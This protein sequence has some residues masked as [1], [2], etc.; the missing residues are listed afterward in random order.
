MGK[1][2]GPEIIER[3][4]VGDI[5]I[6]PFNLKNVGPNSVDLTLNRKL[7]TYDKT[8]LTYQFANESYMLLDMKKQNPTVEAIIP[9]HGLT[10]HPGI[11]YLGV[12]NERAGSDVYVP[13][14]E[15]RSS[16]ARLGLFIHITGGFGDI[17]FK[18]CW[19]L[20]M[21]AIHPIR[22]YPN[23]RICQ[24]YFDTITGDIGD[25]YDKEHRG[26]YGKQEEVAPVASRLYQDFDE[27]LPQLLRS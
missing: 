3:R 11:L 22:I 6:D 27:E 4:S 15:G 8:L 19:T 7:L 26:K 20:E 1:L 25:R 14:I 5:E 16:I 9:E 12:T 21:V 13:S 24:I 17:G 2:T 10:L 23:I 18:G